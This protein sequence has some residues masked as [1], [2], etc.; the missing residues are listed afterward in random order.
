ML[1]ATHAAL[2]R[3]SF[4]SAC[5]NDHGAFKIEQI[6]NFPTVSK[7]NAEIEFGRAAS[8]VSILPRILVRSPPGTGRI[9]RRQSFPFD[10]LEQRLANR[11][12]IQSNTLGT[13]RYA[14]S[15]IAISGPNEPDTTL[16][17]H[18]HYCCGAGILLPGT[19]LWFSDA[20]T[21]LSLLSSAKEV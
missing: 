18:A 13:A 1:V 6:A 7:R 12:Y 9:V 3:F 20:S 15:T 8:P 2:E 17:R 14:V 4:R 10:F 11:K 21:R 16:V 19:V 5:G